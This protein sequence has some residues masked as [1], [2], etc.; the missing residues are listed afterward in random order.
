MSNLNHLIVEVEGV[1]FYTDAATGRSGVS[2]S[3]LAI[4]CGV[5][6]QA[7]SK[8][9]NS[10]STGGGG[11]LL[12]PLQGKVETLSTKTQ[13]GMI[14]Y[15]DELCIAIIRYYDR[16]GNETAQYTFDKFAA[17]GFNSWIQSIT[18]WSNPKA[19]TPKPELETTMPTPEEMDYLRSRDWEKKELEAIDRGETPDYAAIGKEFMSHSGFD[20]AQEAVRTHERLMA[21]WRAF[22]K[23]IGGSQD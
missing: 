23:R 14:L 7:I 4:L 13:S 9:V 8:L 5:S 3:G 20:R 11:K 12:K 6:K 2:Q 18:G 17:I 21:I 16:K 15:A 10:L 1:E 19:P 22:Q